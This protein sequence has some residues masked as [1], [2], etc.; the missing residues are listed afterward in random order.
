MFHVPIAR[1]AVAALLFPSM[2]VFGGE[3][4][5]DL[6]T[7]LD[8]AHKAAP[9]AI[10]AR[11]EIAVAEGAVV[12]AE[13]PFLENPEIEAGAGPRLTAA[14]PVDAEV[15]IEQN[16]EPGRRSPRRRLARA[17]VAQ[18]QAE[19]DAALREVDL[20]VASAFYDALFAERSAEL[21]QRT[22]EFAKR[23]ADAAD[24]RRKA[25]EI[26]DLDANLARSAL[27]RSRATSLSARSERASAV[28]R[29]GALIE[30]APDDVIVL[31]GELRPPPLP[32]VQALRAKA[33]SRPDI[34][35]LDAERAIAAAERDQANANGLPQI[36]AWASYR[37]EDTESIVLGGLRLTLP[38]WNRAQGDKASAAAKE[39]RAIATRDATLRVAER[40]IAD[41]LAAYALARDALDTFERDVLPI[42]D[43]SE[44]LL[45]KTITAGQIAVSDYLVARQEIL[46]GRREHLDRLLA[47]A[48]TAATVRFIAGGAP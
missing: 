16:L 27:G 19:V 44:Q 18:S 32:E 34:R 17:G 39:R 37:R 20:E 45:Q 3:L 9:A 26:T 11:G 35:V 8:R 2:P 29:L 43:D 33:A 1:L 15:R 36:A 48:K 30:A 38:A 31:R 10:A 41:V 25:G 5:I 21:A 14:R 13:L 22:E 24:R 28:G 4:E 40:Q 23:A 6:P 7:A 12:S 42:L 47:L 46:S